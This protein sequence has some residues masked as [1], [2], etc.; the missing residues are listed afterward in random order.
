MFFLL[1]IT[2]AFLSHLKI[3][4][5]KDRENYSIYASSSWDILSANLFQ[6]IIGTLTN[7]PLWLLVNSILSFF[8]FYW[9][10]WNQWLI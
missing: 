9:G 4:V 10:L 6:S 1:C 2:Y 5:F 3:D 8:I 7:E